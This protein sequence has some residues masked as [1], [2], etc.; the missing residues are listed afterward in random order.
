VTLTVTGAG[1]H[2]EPATYAFDPGA[3]GVQADLAHPAQPTTF[4]GYVVEALA[5]RRRAGLP[6]FTVLSCDNVPCNG[7]VARAAVVSF[8]RLRDRRLGDWIDEHV[9]FPSSGS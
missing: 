6:P 3:P 5:R 4:L 8:A 1:Y 2:V 7:R 9:A